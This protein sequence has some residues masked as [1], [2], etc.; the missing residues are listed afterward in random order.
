MKSNADYYM[1]AL[2]KM[3]FADPKSADIINS[4]V[5]E[6]T[7]GKI[8]KIMDSTDEGDVMYLINAVYFKADWL[9]QF[10]TGSIKRRPVHACG[11]DCNS[12]LHASRG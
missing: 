7:S 5:K 12:Y 1:S 8:D 10:V 2:R 6:A 4:W 11:R 3:D 9:N